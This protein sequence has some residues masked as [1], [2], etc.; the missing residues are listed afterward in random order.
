MPPL[1][2]SNPWLPVQTKAQNFK[3]EQS[4]YQLEAGCRGSALVRIRPYKIRKFILSFRLSLIL[5][6]FFGCFIPIQTVSLVDSVPHNRFGSLIQASPKLTDLASLL[7]SYKPVHGARFSATQLAKKCTSKC[8]VCVEESEK[9]KCGDDDA[10]R[11]AHVT[12]DNHHV[13][14]NSSFAHSVINL[15]GALIGLGQLSTPYALENGGWASAF[16][17]I[18]LGTICAYTSHIIR[19]CLD[20]S[21]SSKTYQDLGAAAFGSKGRVLASIFIYLDIF[22]T[23][24]SYTISLSDNIPLVF[25]KTHMTLPHIHISTAQLLTV[26]A[27]LVA[28]PSFWLRD[29]SSISFLS[30]GGILMSFLIFATVI[31]TAIFGGIKANQSIPVFQLHKIPI[32]SGLYA[33]GY[34]GHLVIP[35]LYTAMRNPS[36]FTKVSITSFT[37]VIILYTCQAFIGAKLFGPSFNSQIT[38]SMPP[39]QIATKLALWATVITPITK[40]ALAFAPF[41]IQLDHNLPSSMPHRFRMLIRGSIGSVSLILILVLALSVPYFQYVL[42]LTGSLVSV[43]ISLVF[44]CAFYMK[45]CGENVSKPVRVVN[46]LIMIFGVVIGVAGTISSSKS[47]VISIQRGRPT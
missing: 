22:F 1:V 33:Y 11:L 24:V 26:I 10:S 17:L 9:C 5:F 23:L 18:G 25:G 46:W 40:Y 20:E 27:V 47:L 16:L 31:W 13:K 38:L 39:H 35:N 12:N 2:P 44:P 3:S 28:L 45:I 14:R 42:G 36:N 29:L 19:K 6:F 15:I 7:I 43:G 37:I 30:F 32:I 34:A 8:E 4:A 41:A 21:P